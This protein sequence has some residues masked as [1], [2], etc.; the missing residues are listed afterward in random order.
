MSTSGTVVCEHTAADAD[1]RSRYDDRKAPSGAPL[2]DLP[3]TK[4]KAALEHATG[5]AFTLSPEGVDAV[6][7][8]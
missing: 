8:A 1:G 6:M 2:A 5:G 4:V 3:T 7:E